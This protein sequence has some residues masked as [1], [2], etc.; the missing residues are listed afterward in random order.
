MSTQAKTLRKNPT[1]AEAAMWRLLFPFRTGSFH[2]RKQAPIGPYCVDF[3]CHHARLVIE[4]DGDTHATAQGIRSDARRDT[5]LVA[6]GYRVLRFTNADVLGNPE[7]VLAKIASE[8]ATA[9]PNHRGQLLS[10]ATP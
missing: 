3:A 8:L 5:F 4:V 10:E 6:E 9:Q 2:F 1:P 7:G